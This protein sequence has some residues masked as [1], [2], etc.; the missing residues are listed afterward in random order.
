M[1]K[2][3]LIGAVVV[4]A[5]LF[6]IVLFGATKPAPVKAPGTAA[7]ITLPEGSYVEHA[8]YYDISANYA[9]STPLAGSANLAAVA[10]MK[11]FV[12]DTIAQF[13]TDGNFANLTDEDIKMMGFDQDRKE[14]LQ[15]VYLI[16]SSSRTVSYIFT[17]YEDT[18]GAHGNTFFKTFTFSTKD[19]TELSLSDLFFTGARYLDTLSLTSRSKLPD[20]MGKDATNAR[21]LSDG[22]T[23]DEKNFSSFFLDN[24]EL[25]ILFAPYQVAPYAAGPQTLRIPLSELSSILNSEYR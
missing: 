24:R 1:Q 8:P 23:P 19:G 6:G 5:I 16:A 10:L 14:K 11:N 25:V 12:A 7:Q 3:T 15:I 20:I 17:I 2:N 4:L 9:T 13:K 22:T 21:M 18:L